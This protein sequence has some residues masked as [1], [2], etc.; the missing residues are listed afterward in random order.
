MSEMPREVREAVFE[1]LQWLVSA[2]WEE[3]G[4]CAFCSD[5]RSHRHRQGCPMA[6]IYTWAKETGD[7]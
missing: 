4:Q 2:P 5:S 7:E 6:T 3:H 1:V